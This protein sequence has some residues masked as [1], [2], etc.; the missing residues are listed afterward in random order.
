MASFDPNR[1]DTFRDGPY[2]VQ[3][4]VAEIPER[5]PGV[6]VMVC[7]RRAFGPRKLSA[8]D[9]LPMFETVFRPDGYDFGHVD[10]SKA[11]AHSPVNSDAV[12]YTVMHGQDKVVA[13]VEQDA[14]LVSR[15]T[16]VQLSSG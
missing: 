16:G 10:T 9:M 5:N 15:Q 14:Q 8:S 1:L 13:S 4:Q 6:K 2:F 12:G 3:D 7:R 11:G